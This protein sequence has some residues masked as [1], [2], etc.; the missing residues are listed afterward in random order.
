MHRFYTGDNALSI[1][2]AIVL[3]PQESHHLVHVLRLRKGDR[4]V[5]F[6]SNGAECIGE[7]I[8]ADA[9]ATRLVVRELLSAQRDPAAAITLAVPLLKGARFDLVIQ[10]S[11]EIGTTMLLPFTSQR[12]V[13]KPGAKQPPISKLRRWDR[14]VLDATKQCGRTKLIRVELPLTFAEVLQRAQAATFK[15]LLWEKVGEPLFS[16]LLHETPQVSPS[17]TIFILIG[18]EGGLTDVEAAAAIHAGF[19]PA[20]LGRRILR[21]ETAAIVALA[22]VAARCGEL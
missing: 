17:D 13:V 18:P 8:E 12:S 4:V 1:N 6:S 9:S 19:Q 10:K 5:L 2:G 3:S 15:F 11:V 20:S 16:R 21:A 7:I 14:I 22:L